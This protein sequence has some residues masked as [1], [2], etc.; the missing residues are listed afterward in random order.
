MRRHKSSFADPDPSDLFLYPNK[1]LAFKSQILTA[2]EGTGMFITNLPKSP[3]KR[4][5]CYES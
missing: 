4:T 3:K 1:E 2:K 5:Q